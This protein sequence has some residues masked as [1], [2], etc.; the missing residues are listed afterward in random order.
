MRVFEVD[1]EQAVGAPP[2]A[3]AGI[4]IGSNE[5]VFTRLLRP[6]ANAPE[7]RLQAPPAQL[8]FWLVDNW[9]RI[10]WECVPPSG[11]TPDWRL[12]HELGSIGGYAW[13]RLAIWGEGS[14]IG[15]SS[16]RDPAGVVGPVRY[17][18]DALTYVPAEAFET[19]ADNFLELVADEKSG[20]ASDWAALRSRVDALV[21]ERGDA[22]LAT[23]R[24]L[25][26]LLGYDVDE[27]PETLITTLHKLELEYGVGAI[28]EA[29]LATQGAEA[30]VVLEQEIAAVNDNHWQC[31][32]HRTA[33]LVGRIERRPE[34]PPWR[35]GEIA[36]AAVRTAVGH[37]TGPLWNKTLSEILGVRQNA[38]KGVRGTR[39]LAYGLRLS[40]GLEHGDIVALSSRWSTDR[41]FEFARA[42]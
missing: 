42:W 14:R 36:A 6:G 5:I 23:W 17:L 4:A 20:L 40:A 18:T 28:A 26:A 38:L 24:R 7:D 19:E 21:T 22:D 13:P 3:P 41:R 10:R 37:P 32:L 12:A 27:A 33:D 35:L 2:D 8:A 34:D 15:L 29:A 9:W 25:E 11:P 1:V 16:R 30:A 39:E 31:D